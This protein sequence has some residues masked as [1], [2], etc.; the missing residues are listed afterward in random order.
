MEY[1]RSELMPGVF[2]NHLRSDKFKT[3]F[4]SVSL[5]T[6]LRRETAAMN[7]LIPA[8]LRR[9]TTRYG[10]MEQLSQ[11]LDELYGTAIEPIVRRFGEI[12]SFGFFAS[13]PEP[14]FLPGG[15]ALLGEVTG[16]MA[17][18][19]L[20]PS[21]RGGLLLPQYVDSEKEKLLDLI[22]SRVNEKRSYAVQR[23]LEEMCCFEDYAVSRFGDLETCGSIQY[24][25][26]TKHYRNL[27]RTC[28]VELF[29]C[30]RATAREAEDAF[31]EALAGMPR[32]AID[33]DIGTDVRLNAVEAEPRFV[34]E[35]MAVTQGKL[36]LGFRLGEYMETPNIPALYVFNALYGS[37][38]TSRL[39]LNVREKLS[40]CY[41]ASSA[42]VIRKGLMIVSSG[43]SFDKF[44][45]AKAEILSQLE[46]VR[47]GEITDEELAR[48]KR[49]VA[50]DLRATLDSPGDLE[51]FWLGQAV[52][53]Q[54]CSPEELAVLAEDVT[55][56]DMIAIAKSI[57][58]DM[59]YFLRGADSFGEEEEEDEA[60]DED[61][62][63]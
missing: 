36:V 62:Q 33:Y 41:Y 38:A 18:M 35:R 34:E 27:L 22:R 60:E 48:A 3:A 59:V 7:A 53:G 13:F 28:P 24:K 55:R 20:S 2:L 31:R 40:L 25:K 8:V 57:E 49:A 44:E 15:E 4:M 23:C 16:L 37:G 14:A 19:L 10:D 29:Y 5:L 32:G 21:T 9:G 52:D 17:E 54:E 12:H 51:G 42:L 30:G 39:F 56:E 63:A 43:I 46:A 50:S 58:L 1:T 11:R 26:L 6:Q 45:A 47:R 61:T